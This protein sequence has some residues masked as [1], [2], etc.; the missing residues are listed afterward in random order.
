MRIYLI[1]FMGCGKTTL[2]KKLSARLRYEFVDLDKRMENIEKKSIAEIF[3][4]KGEEYFRELERDVLHSTILHKNAVI[5]CGGG[6]PCYHSNMEWM[7]EKGTTVYIKM[8]PERLFGRLR[9]RKEKRPLIAKMNDGELKDYI[10][11]KLAE[12]EIF[13]TQAKLIVDPDEISVKKLVGIIGDL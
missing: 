6:T 2:G 12:R 7:K 4:G 13:Y 3:S 11:S 5:S 10:F 9:T 8:Q 1:G